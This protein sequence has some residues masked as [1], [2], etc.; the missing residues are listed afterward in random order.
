MKSA[1][2]NSGDIAPEYTYV[3]TAR[4]YSVITTTEYSGVV[5]VNSVVSATQYTAETA[6]FRNS[7]FFATYYAIISCSLFNCV[8]LPTA[9]KTVYRCAIDV[10]RCSAT[11]ETKIAIRINTISTSGKYTG[12][13]AENCICS[14]STN[15]TACAK[16]SI[17]ITTYYRRKIAASLIKCT[18]AYETETP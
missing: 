1:I 7:I 5:A 6:V 13:F 9:Y 12:I 16:Y 11:Y 2:S 15:N 14:T 8:A 3:T 10:V 4:W 17:R 18:A